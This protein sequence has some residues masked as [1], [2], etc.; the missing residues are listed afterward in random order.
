MANTKQR[1]TVDDVQG[2]WAIMPTP[3]RTDASDWRVEN[4]VDLDEAARLAEE[5]VRSGVDGILS[6]GTFG[7]ASTLTWDEKRAF[8]QTVVDTVAGRI[9]FFAGT[10][11]LNTRETIRQTREAHDIGADG[12]MLGL[13]MWQV[14]DTIGAVQYYRDIAEACPEMAICLYANPEAFKFDYP[15]AFWKQVAEIP[16]VITSKTVGVAT[17][18]RDLLLT[19]RKIRF[20]VSDMNY[21]AAARIDPDFISAFWS[22]GVNCGPLPALR[23]RDLVAEAKRT[24]DWTGAVAHQNALLHTIQTLLPNGSFKD[25]STYNIALEKARIDAGGW[26]KAGPCR[27][28]YH[29]TPPAL[30]EGAHTSGRRWADLHAKLAA[31]L[32]QEASAA[33]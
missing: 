31:E 28:P 19:Q 1:L 25:F 10:T 12:T 21:V 13:P 6:L 23:L 11:S 24:G 3:S 29:L 5:L 15:G 30:L 2:V 18:Y 8:I 14:T 4:T 22:S 17:I 16:Q 20:M 27:P 7:E 32:T 33:E 26:A 9:P